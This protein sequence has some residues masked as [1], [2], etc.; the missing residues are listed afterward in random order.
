MALPKWLTFDAY[1]TLVDF[2]LDRTTVEILGSR[3]DGI[4][5]HAFLTRYQRIRFEETFGVYR[6]YRDLLRRSLKRITREFGLEY[7]AEDA[8]ALVAAVPT[9]GPFPDVPP[10]LETLGR[11][12]KLAIISNTD[13]DL[14]PGNVEKLGVPIDRVFTAQE[15]QAYKPSLT[16]FRYML[17]QLGVGWS[18][19]VHVAQ[20]FD[21]DIRPAHE[22]GLQKVWINRRNLP[23][24]PAFGP[25]VELPD[26]SGV[27]EQLG[28][29]G[30]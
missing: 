28:I 12:C 10:V 27:P 1:G 8:D 14:I 2:A 16:V 24:N 6:P 19:V 13:N 23:G 20:G 3:L 25:Y 5:Q 30:S 18:E 22:L 17:D 9:Y 11:Q 29:S 21:Y 15:V 26:L 7:R 4:D